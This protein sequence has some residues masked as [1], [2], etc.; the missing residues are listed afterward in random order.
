[1]P[2]YRVK[3]QEII[4]VH[5]GSGE[6]TWELPD[7]TKKTEYAENSSDISFLDFYEEIPSGRPVLIQ[8]EGTIFCP[9]CKGEMEE[10]E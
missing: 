5:S 2:K 1:M 9:S 6:W 4:A 10:K 7:G 8:F 3:H